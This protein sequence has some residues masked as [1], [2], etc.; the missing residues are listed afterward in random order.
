M[1]NNKIQKDLY[2]HVFAFSL[3]L[4]DL[5]YKLNFKE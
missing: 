4:E 3:I 5:F 1:K 2:L